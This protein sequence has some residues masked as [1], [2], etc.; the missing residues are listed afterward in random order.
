M[1]VINFGGGV[2]FKLPFCQHQ[3]SQFT[4]VP[5]CCVIRFECLKRVAK[6]LVNLGWVFIPVSG[7]SIFC[8]ITDSVVHQVQVSCVLGIQIQ[9]A[10]VQRLVL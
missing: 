2:G 6:L 7:E 9:A 5:L 1:R 10:P 3:S 8:H 4:Q